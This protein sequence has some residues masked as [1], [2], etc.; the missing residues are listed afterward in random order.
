MAYTICDETER[1]KAHVCLRYFYEFF[2]MFAKRLYLCD[3]FMNISVEWKE[4][5]IMM[6]LY[7][8]ND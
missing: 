3:M 7:L 4:I 6:L 8:T 2:Y 5:I 1:P